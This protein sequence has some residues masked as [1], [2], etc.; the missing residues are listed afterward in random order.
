MFALLETVPDGSR[1]PASGRAHFQLNAYEAYIKRG[2]ALEG[3]AISNPALVVDFD[4]QRFA[5]RLDVHAGSL[6][7]P[8]HVVGGGD[9]SDAGLLRSD[10]D[11]P[12]RLEGALAGEGK[13]AGLLF[14]YQVSPG[15]DAIGATHWVNESE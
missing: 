11:S 9:M 12:S 10:A 2:T 14:E 4:T 7:G 5:T 8:V 6:P 3:A 15:V 1:A 13:E